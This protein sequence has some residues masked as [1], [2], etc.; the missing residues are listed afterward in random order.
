MEHWAEPRGRCDCRKRYRKQ[1]PCGA[2]QPAGGGG[3]SNRR[4]DERSLL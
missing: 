4:L 2:F 1:T 3:G